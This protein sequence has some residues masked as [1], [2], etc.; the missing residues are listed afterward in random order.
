MRLSEQHLPRG[1]MG[2]RA[3]SWEHWCQTPFPSAPTPSPGPSSRWQFRSFHKHFLSTSCVPVQML[4]TGEKKRN[5]GCALKKL[6]NLV[7]EMDL[8][9]ALWATMTQLER[10]GA[11]GRFSFGGAGEGPME[12]LAFELTFKS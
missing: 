2:R 6:N 7:E 12:A 1:S 3:A 5:H 8:Y 11:K 10:T 4:G 9:R